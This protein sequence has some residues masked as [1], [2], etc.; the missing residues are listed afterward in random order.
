MP[1]VTV[2][3]NIDSDMHTWNRGRKQAMPGV[4]PARGQAHHATYPRTPKKREAGGP[5]NSDGETTDDTRHARVARGVQGL[6]ISSAKFAR[7]KPLV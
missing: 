1:I 7:R 4:A 5:T 3:V 6:D 2:C